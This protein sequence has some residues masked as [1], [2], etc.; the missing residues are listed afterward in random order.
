MTE[1][2]HVPS[3]EAVVFVLQEF[4]ASTIF[5]KLLPVIYYHLY[6]SLQDHLDG[7]MNTVD[8]IRTV[9]EE[10]F[11]SQTSEFWKKSLGRLPYR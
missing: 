3:S 11:A 2:Y 4:F 5:A 9:L 8:E 10:Y 1:Y 6:L 7:H